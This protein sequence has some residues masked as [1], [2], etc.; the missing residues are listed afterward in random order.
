[1]RYFIVAAGTVR[2]GLKPHR[3]TNGRA[4]AETDP[5]GT[6]RR[7]KK[8]GSQSRQ[9]QLAS[10]DQLSPSH[11]DRSAHGQAPAECVAEQ[12]GVELAKPTTHHAT[13]ASCSWHEN[14]RRT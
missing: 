10:V 7:L 9:Q 12:L 6:Q 11:P 5:P 13:E 4:P 2:R 1:M 3:V 14:L 8:L